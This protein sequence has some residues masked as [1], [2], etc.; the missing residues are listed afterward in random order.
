[1]VAAGLCFLCFFTL[2]AGLVVSV[3]ELEA[4]GVFAITV[5]IMKERP[6]KA[7]AKVFMVCI[8]LFLGCR[9]SASTMRDVRAY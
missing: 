3:V 2:L 1:M 4:A 8:P 6:I 9:Y 5:P 7:V